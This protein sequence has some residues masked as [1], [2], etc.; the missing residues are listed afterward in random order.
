MSNQSQQPYLCLRDVRLNLGARRVLD[1]G[2]LSLDSG[3]IV[4]LT[5]ANGSGK[6]SLLK[7]LA[8]LISPQSGQIECNGTPMP[9]RK[10]MA[11]WRGRHIYLHQQPYLFDTTVAANVGYGL[12]LRGHSRVQRKI[13]VREALAWARLE[14]LGER[15]AHELSTGERQRVALTRAKIL[16]PAALLVDEITANMDNESRNQS[17]TLLGELSRSGVTVVVASHEIGQ[18]EDIADKH[19]TLDAGKLDHSRESADVI[20]LDRRNR[21]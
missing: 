10:A 3:S 1:I 20:V 15:S 16:N 21:P 5:G 2:E 17:K 4:L 8:G 11:Y 12:E 13:Q 18:F 7:I 6:T 19:L 9:T 14:H